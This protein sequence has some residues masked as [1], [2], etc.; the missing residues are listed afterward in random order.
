MAEYDLSTTIVPFLDR[1]L[2][3]PILA[4]LSETKLFDEKDVLGAQYELAKG[5]NM[6]DY[7]ATLFDQLYQDEQV[8]DGPSRSHLYCLINLS[9]CY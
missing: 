1:H 3:F 5:T 9:D 8:P 2:S 7:A 6:F 4:H